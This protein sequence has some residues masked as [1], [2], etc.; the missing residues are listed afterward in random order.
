M[1]KSGYSQTPRLLKGA[2]IYFG[3]AMLIPVPNIIVFQYNPESMTRTLNPWQP[4][5]LVRPEWERNE[6]TGQYTM[7]NK[8]AYKEYLSKVGLLAQPYDPQE[9]FSLVLEL[10]ATDALETPDKHPVA[11]LTGVADRLAAIEMLM[12]PPGDSLLGSLLGSV[13]ASVSVSAGGVSFGA[14]GGGALA[15]VE[16]K[17]APIV[18]F[19]WGPGRI[20]PVRITSLAI[21][22]QQFSPTLY[23]LRAKATIG[24]R[25]LDL[26][27]LVMV[28]GNPATGAVV[29]IAKGCYM[30]TRLQKEALATANLLNSAESIIGMLP[31]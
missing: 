24:V 9:T 23:P 19:F 22:E 27:D 4:L 7:T 16:R 17:E 14:A 26:D 31:I 29:T 25:V 30:F 10:D 13:G 12:Y 6:E 5:T 1:P 11:S 18:L 2:L 8:E 3:S 20:V 28:D 15:S 21:E